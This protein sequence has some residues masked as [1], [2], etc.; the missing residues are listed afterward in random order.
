M[1]NTIIFSLIAVILIA[2]ALLL[3]VEDKPEEVDTP[4]SNAEQAL[5]DRVSTPEFGDLAEI[6]ERRLL[7][8]LVSYSKTN[9]FFDGPEI[10]GFDYE[11]MR[12]YEK[13]LN[14]NISNE[15]NKTVATFI[16][17]PF[18]D[19]L[20]DL[21]EGRGDI[22]V[23]NFTITPERQKLVEFTEP[24]FSK[25]SEVIVQNK[26]TTGLNSLDDLSGKSLYLLAGSSFIQHA[27]ELNE[28]LTEQGLK[29]AKILEAPP[30]LT[31]EDIFELINAGIYTLTVADDFT[32]KAWQDVLPNI[33]VREDLKINAG[34]EIAWAVRK[35]SN[36]LLDSLNQFIADI[37]KGTLLGNIF[38]KRYYENSKWIDD[39][40]APEQASRLEKYKS[41]FQ[42]YAAEHNFDWL[43]VAAMAYQESRIDQSKVSPR[44]AVGIMQIKPDTAASHEV[45][46][47]DIDNGENNINAGVKYLAYLRDR[48]FS[49]DDIAPEDQIDFTWAAYNAGP[50]RIN[51]LRELAAENGYD[52]NKWFF[53]VER[54]AAREIGRE[55]V[56]Y[57]A[58]VNKYYIAYKLAENNL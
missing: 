54:M 24:Y 2:A 6:K 51:R 48:Y 19:I 35:D 56:Q 53:N 33:V 13:L 23:A 31:S 5:I 58:N 21:V 11:I 29:P 4:A 46:I 45:G 40:T 8:V 41:L 14:Q 10:K 26:S 36:E 39:P 25:V 47:P 52:P 3:I 50:A 30:N 22:A 28:Q 17:R 49:S 7:R 20:A 55:T 12:E 34:G 38:F 37:R 43:S 18:A 32:A 15:A 9:F 1:K 42:K 57:V 16:V 44:G 27:E